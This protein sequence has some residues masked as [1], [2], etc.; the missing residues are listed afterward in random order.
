VVDG[1]SLAMVVPL[2]M[3]TAWRFR[4]GAGGGRISFGEANRLI[5]SASVLNLILPSK[6]GDIA[7]AIFIP[8]CARSLALS[9]VVFE[10]AMRHALAAFV[11]RV[12]LIWVRLD[13]GKALSAFSPSTW[14]PQLPVPDP[15]LWW[16]RRESVNWSCF[17]FVGG[18]LTFGLLLLGSQRFASESL[19]RATVRTREDE[20]KFAKLQV[21]WN[22]MHAY[23]WGSKARLFQVTTKS[24]FIWLLQSAANLVLHFRA[25]RYVSLPREPRALAAG[26]PRRTRAAH[27]RWH[28]Q[29]ATSPSCSSTPL[30]STRP[31]RLHWAS[32]ALRDTSFPRSVGVPFFH[33]YTAGD[34][35]C[36]CGDRNAASVDRRFWRH[37]KHC[38]FDP[39]GI[40]AGSRCVI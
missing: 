27:L 36:E 16:A 25:A 10:K 18:S 17:A 2:T 19:G 32:S 28:R 9:L 14:F 30:S 1:A 26:H 24:V 33:R 13:G 20:G 22:A 37:Q 38:A 5:L 34:S 8:D 3:F 4:H 39:E 21:S 31:P 23:F 15:L 40:T 12:W 35:A 11:V 29:R 6:M 7:K